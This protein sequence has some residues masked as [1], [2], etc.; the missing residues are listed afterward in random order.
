MCMYRMYRI[1]VLYR[2]TVEL[3]S[4]YEIRVKRISY[5]ITVLIIIVVCMYVCMYV[6]VYLCVYMYVYIYVCV[7][8]AFSVHIYIFPKHESLTHS[9]THSFAPCSIKSNRVSPLA[10]PYSA[11]NSLLVFIMPSSLVHINIGIKLRVEPLRLAQSVSQLTKTVHFV[12]KCWPCM[13]LYLRGMES[14][15]HMKHK[16]VLISRLQEIGMSEEMVFEC[17]RR[18]DKHNLSEYEDAKEARTLWRLYHLAE[19]VYVQIYT[20]IYT[21]IY[22]HIYTYICIHYT[23]THTHTYIYIYIYIH[24]HTYIHTY[25][26]I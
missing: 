8:M 1:C 14:T 6:C 11:I 24:I 26:Y 17:L 4:T 22:I 10:A 7:C 5:L 19:T 3:H 21:Y 15:T 20:Y 16:E 12:S 25:T 23:D 9:L 2:R 18:K 13:N